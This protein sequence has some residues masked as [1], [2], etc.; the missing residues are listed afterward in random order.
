MIQCLLCQALVDS[1]LDFGKGLFAVII[2]VDPSFS[3]F[4]AVFRDRRSG[5]ES[6]LLQLR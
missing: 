2:V 4:F 3:F 1:L 5:V 6:A